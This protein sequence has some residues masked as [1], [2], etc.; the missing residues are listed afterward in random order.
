MK[1]HL[2]TYF[3]IILSLPPCTS[4]YIAQQYDGVNPHVF[5]FDTN[6]PWL[7]GRKEN[8]ALSDRAFL[9]AQPKFGKF[10][11]LLLMKKNCVM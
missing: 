7:L 9:H 4:V 5:I 8:Q 11:V 3:S 1:K 6:V 2:V 10:I